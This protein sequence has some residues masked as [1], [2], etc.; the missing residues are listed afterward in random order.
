MILIE[1]YD[2]TTELSWGDETSVLRYICGF[3]YYRACLGIMKA[4]DKTGVL[5]SDIMV[6]CHC[7]LASK[8][9][10]SVKLVTS[11]IMEESAFWD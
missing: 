6:V 8:V 2:Q 5:A 1:N 3:I 9:V 4:L 7:K 11:L 10:H